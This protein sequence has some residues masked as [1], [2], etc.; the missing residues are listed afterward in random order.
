MNELVNKMSRQT[1]TELHEILKKNCQHIYVNITN[2]KNKIKT[3]T[4]RVLAMWNPKYTWQVLNTSF[5]YSLLEPL[6]TTEKFKPRMRRINN[7]Y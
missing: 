2:Y 3:Y 1:W 6:A 5:I 4:N 7:E